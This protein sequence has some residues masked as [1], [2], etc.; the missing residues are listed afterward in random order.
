MTQKPP[1]IFVPASKL[2]VAPTNVRKRTDPAADEELK[3]LILAK[4]VIQNLVGLPVPRKKGEY[5]ITAGGRRLKQVQALIAE[6]KFDPDHTVPVLVLTDKN[7]AV[8]ISLVEN[9]GRLNMTPAEECRAFQAIIEI[10]KKAPADVAKRFGV[11]ERFVLGR[12][13]LAGLADII[14]EALA[15]GE[16]TLDVAKAYASISDPVRQ[17]TVFEELGDGWGSTNC[18]EIRRRLISGFYRGSDPKALL[19]GRDAYVA[20]GGRI[21]SD[22]FSDAANENWIDSEILERLADERM[23]AAAEEIQARDGFGELRVVCQTRVPYM[24]VMAL[25]EIEG[26]SVPLTQEEEDRQRAIEQE[27]EAIAENADED[28]YSDEEQQVIQTLEAEYDALNERPPVLADHQKA[29]S[30]A[31]L[32]IGQDGTPRLHEQFY[33]IP[34]P[35]PEEEE[36]EGEVSEDVEQDEEP[37]EEASSRSPISQRLADEMAIMKTELLRVHVASDPHFALDLGTFFMVDATLGFRHDLPSDLRATA[38]YS[39][40]PGF[41]SDTP[42]AEQWEELKEGLD[43]SWADSPDITDRYEAFCALG[44]D[45]R[46]SWLGWAIAR[47]LHAVP[48]GGSGSAMLDHLGR[49]LNINVADWWRPTARRYFDRVSKTTILGHFEEVGGVELRNRYGASKKHDLSLSAEKLFGGQIIVEA[50]VKERAL[51]WVPEAM[52]F[53]QDGEAPHTIDGG[54]DLSD[55]DSIDQGGT[56]EADGLSEAA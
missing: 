19:V 56:D 14:F 23:Q 28:G 16:I 47:T 41:E 9:V 8:E 22:L 43:R 54:D 44:D 1:I 29:G 55:S 40:M 4:G 33:A 25:D 15:D 3:A 30:L 12:L 18:G 7:D 5:L 32:V 50:A 53:D 21:D 45:A 11:T 42:A 46:A 51:A 37:A 39:R 20:A 34:A 6:G 38:P 24:D 2:T 10:E 27:L 26:E 17:A 36:F 31:Y 13:R 35:E 49:K 48:A 52:R